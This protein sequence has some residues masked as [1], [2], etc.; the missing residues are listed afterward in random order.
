LIDIQCRLAIRNTLFKPVLFEPT[1]SAIR[2]VFR[3]IVLEADRFCV[4]FLSEFKVSGFERS[5][6]LCVE[7]FGFGVHVF[8]EFFVDRF[9][10]EF[11][12]V[13]IGFRRIFSV[14]F[15]G[16]RIF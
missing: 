16:F 11:V 5:V 7:G 1:N 9:G 10:K 6:S 4:T 2:S 12:D 15:S 13:G 3:L 14:G 8:F